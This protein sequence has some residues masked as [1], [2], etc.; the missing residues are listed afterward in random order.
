MI[1][2]RAL[3]AFESA[4]FLARMKY[5]ENNKRKKI[6]YDRK[7][8][9]TDEHRIKRWQYEND[10][11]DFILDYLE[12]NYPNHKDYPKRFM[13]WQGNQWR[14]Y[15]TFPTDESKACDCHMDEYHCGL[16][17]DSGCYTCCYFCYSPELC[18]WAKCKI[19]KP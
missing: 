18:E 3:N 6:S 9:H 14:E 12:K 7:D 19:L 5:S 16:S 15:L 4:V 2:M 8:K 17:R 13:E 1:I 11:I 10:T